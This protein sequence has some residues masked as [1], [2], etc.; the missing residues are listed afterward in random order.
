MLDNLG[1]LANRHRI[2]SAA[3]DNRLYQY[4]PDQAGL[5]CLFLGTVEE[6]E[7]ITSRS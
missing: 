1:Q 3:V 6:Q 4:W 2:H 5:F 7:P